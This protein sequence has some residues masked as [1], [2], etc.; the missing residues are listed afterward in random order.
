SDSSQKLR[1]DLRSIRATLGLPPGVPIPAGIGFLGWVLDRTETSEDPRLPSVLQ[2]MPK[3][4]MF[5]FGDDL[6]K[7]VAQVR[8]FDAQREHKTI[9]FL[10]VNSLEEALRATNEWKVDVL[11]VQ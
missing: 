1:D 11:V 5:A 10:T 6:G 2:E 7:Y 4:I 8:S 3:A 9:V